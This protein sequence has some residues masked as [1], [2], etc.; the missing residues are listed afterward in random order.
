MDIERSEHTAP[1]NLRN[2]NARYAIVKLL[3]DLLWS[4][5]RIRGPSVKLSKAFTRIYNPV[6]PAFTGS[7][8]PS[9]WRK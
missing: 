1:Q 9:S 8:L 4:Y 5:P 7:T 6:Y 2:F 3:D